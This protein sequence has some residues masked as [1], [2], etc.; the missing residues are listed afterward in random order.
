LSCCICTS[1]GYVAFSIR[2]AQVFI[3]LADMNA[4]RLAKDLSEFHDVLSIVPRDLYTGICI[5]YSMRDASRKSEIIN[6]LKKGLERLS[7]GFPL[8]TGQVIEDDPPK[9]RSSNPLVIPLEKN[10]R[11]IEKDYSSND[12]VPSMAKLIKARFPVSMIN[13][14]A[15]TSLTGG[16]DRLLESEGAKKPMFLVQASFIDG[17][18]VLGFA[19]HHAFFDGHGSAQIMRMLSNACHDLPFTEDELL[20]GNRARDNVVPLLDPTNYRHTD[21]VKHL[22]LH[23]SGWVRPTLPKLPSS[24]WA[25]FRFTPSNLAK[26]KFLASASSPTS[27]SP[28]VPYTTT[29]DALTAFVWQGY[30]RARFPRL[31]TEATSMFLRA[32]DVRPSLSIPPTYLGNMSS[33]TY[34]RLPISTLTSCR[35]SSLASTLRS[36]LNSSDIAYGMRSMATWLTYETGDGIVTYGKDLDIST[37]VIFS[38]WAR[39]PC[40]NLDFNLGLGFPESV[41]RPPFLEIESLSYFMPMDRDGAIDAMLC[42]RDEDLEVLKADEEFRKYAEYIG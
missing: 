14:P 20:Q 33:H 30:A 7:T 38:S 4:P 5:F 10:V 36:Q 26:L 40:Y 12:A 32:V 24:T 16:P 3:V 29:N 28:L 37:D 34:T 21:E 41:R 39:L 9:G 1:L 6:T 23:P 35:L 27:E 22:I 8:L 19:I 11:L 18:L 13:G 42:L 17:G 31:P 25:I 2:G 15:F